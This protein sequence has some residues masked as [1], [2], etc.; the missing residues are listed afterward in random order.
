M[1]SLILRIALTPSA[2][3][4]REHRLC[5]RELAQRV[6]KINLECSLDLKAPRL[7]KSLES[8]SRGILRI[9]KPRESG[10]YRL[11]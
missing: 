4:A 9:R 6:F 3:A 11:T 8:R 1:R 2:K 10:L 7:S 5:K